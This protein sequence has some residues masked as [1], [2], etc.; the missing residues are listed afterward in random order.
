MSESR[1]LDDIARLNAERARLEARRA[2][3]IARAARDTQALQRL[4][5]RSAHPYWI[6]S[7]PAKGE[8]R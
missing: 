5:F 8:G 6:K 2:E 3:R 1:F 7:R 4:A